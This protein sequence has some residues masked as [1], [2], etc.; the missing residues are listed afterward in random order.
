MSTV[1]EANKYLKNGRNIFPKFFLESSYIK[2]T[3]T[4]I[5]Q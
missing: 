1:G 4:P 2:K 3:A 5:N